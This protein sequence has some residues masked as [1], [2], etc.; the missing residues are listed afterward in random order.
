[1]KDNFYLSKYPVVSSSGEEYRVDICPDSHLTGCVFCGIFKAV[2]VRKLFGGYKTKF[3]QLNCGGF[4]PD[5]YD[6]E[7]WNFDYIA[8]ARREIE[9]YEESIRHQLAQEIGHKK[10]VNAFESWDGR[11]PE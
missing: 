9:K 2:E 1:M 11:L 5:L 4:F 3:K 7:K 10:G 6:V 8:I